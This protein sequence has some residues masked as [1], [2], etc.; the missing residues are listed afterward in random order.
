MGRE[1]IKILI[2]R[3]WAKIKP[4]ISIDV[5]KV[6]WSCFI[7]PP[8]P[9]NWPPVPGSRFRYY[10]FAYGNDISG[11]L[12][13]ACHVAAPWA[14]VEVSAEDEEALTVVSL[15]NQVKD[16][17]FQGVEPLSESEFTI[18]NK[19]NEVEKYLL[20]LQVLPEEESIE[21]KKLRDYYRNWCSY[22]GVLANN[23]K[24]YHKRFFRWLDRP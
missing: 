21:I 6:I 3:E 8:F 11:G 12:R 7:S 9:L 22:N 2:D 24:P 23:I 10:A 13:D 18:L 16:I 15:S 19:A 20:S 14:L 5:D 1:L 17:G 4:E